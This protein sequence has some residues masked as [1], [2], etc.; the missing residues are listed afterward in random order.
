MQIVCKSCTKIAPS[1]GLHHNHAP[2]QGLMLDSMEAG[3]RPEDAIAQN[4]AKG[5]RKRHKSRVYW[6]W[7]GHNVVIVSQVKPCFDLVSSLNIDTTY[8]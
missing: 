4:E 7:F 2:S 1:Q 6:T 5:G 8:R 3:R